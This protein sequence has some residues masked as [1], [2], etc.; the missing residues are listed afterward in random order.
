[1]KSLS[2]YLF[3]IC[4]STSL[5]KDLAPYNFQDV[6]G[7]PFPCAAG[8]IP[9]SQGRS[10]AEAKD[11]EMVCVADLVLSFHCLTVI[12]AVVTKARPWEHSA[13]TLPSYPAA[14]LSGNTLEWSKAVGAEL[15]VFVCC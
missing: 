13:P 3:L 11:G 6:Y 8:R 1:M 5:L 12:P 7:D 9:T 10:K 15:I 4:A 14:Y 2:S